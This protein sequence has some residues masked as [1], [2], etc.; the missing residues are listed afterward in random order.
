MYSLKVITFV[1][2]FFFF[3]FQL[4]FVTFCNKVVGWNPHILFHIWVGRYSLLFT[5][6][7]AITR[8]SISSLMSSSHCSYSTLLYGSVSQGL[9]TT[10]LTNLIG[11]NRYWPWSRFSHLDR[12]L[13]RWCFAV[14]RC[15]L[16][17]KNIEYFLL[18]IFIYGSAKQHDDKRE[19]GEQTLTE[20]SSAHRH[21]SPFASKMSVSTNQLH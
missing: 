17:C 4:G 9:G 15:K 11:W 5:S 7:D 2:F 8:A 3:W 1:S 12:H 18:P 16:K 19:D 13:D 10:K 21:S 6:V 14:K 20:L